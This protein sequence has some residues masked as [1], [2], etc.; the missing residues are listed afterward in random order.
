MATCCILLHWELERSSV[1]GLRYREGPTGGASPSSPAPCPTAPI[2]L[3]RP[4][5]GP[6]QACPYRPPYRSSS[7]TIA[8]MVSLKTPTA[9][10][11]RRLS[12][13]VHR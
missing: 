10:S 4:Q 5:I 1:P 13:N 7:L 2:W 12:S 11:P 3:Q 9:V 6:C 8:S